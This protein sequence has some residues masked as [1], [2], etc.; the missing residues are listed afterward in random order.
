MLSKESG[1]IMADIHQLLLLNGRD[2]A[3]QLVQPED[4]KLIDI[5]A[6]VMGSESQ[7]LDRKSVV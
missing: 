4:K 7:D 5:A 3:R 1:A 6:T 2:A